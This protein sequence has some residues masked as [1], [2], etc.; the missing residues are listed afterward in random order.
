MGCAVAAQV[1]MHICV[2]AFTHTHVPGYA[3]PQSVFAYVHLNVV[4]RR[5]LDR[6]FLYICVYL[7]QG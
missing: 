6:F 2:S 3:N 1:Q 5:C 4:F 7:S